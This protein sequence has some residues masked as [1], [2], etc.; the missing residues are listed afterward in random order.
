MFIDVLDIISAFDPLF[1]NAEYCKLF[2]NGK[3]YKGACCPTVKEVI[4]NNPTTIVRFT[5]GSKAVVKCSENDE[6]NLETA[7]IYAIVKRTFCTEFSKDGE[8]ICPGLGNSLRKIVEKAKVAKTAV[9]YKEPKKVTCHC[10]TKPK[11]TS[12]IAA[13]LEELDWD[14]PVTKKPVEKAAKKR[15]KDMTQEEKRAYWREQKR[16]AREV[17]APVVEDDDDNDYNW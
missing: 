7:V 4:D 11:K 9:G 3:L 5:D 2:A 13:A 10:D 15:F 16:K 1:K 6:Y 8:A 17:K 14:K 12:K